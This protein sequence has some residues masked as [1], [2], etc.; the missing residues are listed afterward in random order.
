MRTLL[1]DAE[2]AATTSS[3]GAEAAAAMDVLDTRLNGS[4]AEGGA[5]A[6]W[7]AALFIAGAVFSFG[8]SELASLEARGLRATCEV[9]AS[10]G[11]LAAAVAAAAF[12]FDADLETA[13][14]AGGFVTVAD[15]AVLAAAGLR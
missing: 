4:F 10:A 3:D 9:I 8:V 15:A 14:V 2:I 6:G 11:C 13:A 12:L 1:F 7:T 5:D